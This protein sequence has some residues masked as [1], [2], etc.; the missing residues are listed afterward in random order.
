MAFSPQKSGTS[1]GRR[2]RMTGSFSEINVTPMVDVMLVLLVI[3][4]VTAP[5]MTVGVPVDLPQAIAPVLEGRE[6]PLV[7]SLSSKGDIYIQETKV[8]LETLGPR[9]TAITG[10]NPDIKITVRGDKNI[11]YGEVMALMGAITTAGFK[12][13]A[14]VSQL[15]KKG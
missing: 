7:V 9:L 5:M 6:E 10:A 1:S 14:L 13:V 11:S 8:T 2:S 4:M 15:P 3:F 12:R